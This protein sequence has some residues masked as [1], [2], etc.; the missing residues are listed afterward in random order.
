MVVTE[1]A[2]RRLARL[3]QRAGERCIGFRFEGAIGTCRASSPIL[4][5]VQ[6]PVEGAEAFRAGQVWIYA[7]GDHA[8][9]LRQATLDFDG[10][11]FGPGLTLAWP[12][13]EGGCPNCR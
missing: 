5:P 10:A 12:H 11:F 7:V 6:A 9:I 2:C 3:G 4:K 8:D 1:A 13:R